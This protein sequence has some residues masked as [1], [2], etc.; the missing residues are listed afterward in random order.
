MLSKLIQQNTSIQHVHQYISK[1]KAS[2]PMYHLYLC[3]ISM[4]KVHWLMRRTADY[5]YKTIPSVT[6]ENTI[7]MN[8]PGTENHKGILCVW[9]GESQYLLLAIW[10]HN[11]N[12]IFT[13]FVQGIAPL[14]HRA[15]TS[16]M[17]LGTNRIWQV[18]HVH[19]RNQH[20]CYLKIHFGYFTFKTCNVS[21]PLLFPYSKY[22]RPRFLYGSK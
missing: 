11:I 21:I 2:D 20:L 12:I 22:L 5:M 16:M 17:S 15:H 6:S 19:L 14:N 13:H 7:Y 9:M 10:A 8:Q 3:K 1:G 4:H 18:F